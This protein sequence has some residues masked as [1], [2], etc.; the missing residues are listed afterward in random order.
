M[1]SFYATAEVVSA[2]GWS[3]DGDGGAGGVRCCCGRE[4]RAVA[5]RS[6]WRCAARARSSC[7]LSKHLDSS[8]QEEIQ[9]RA[10]VS[11]QRFTVAA[12]QSASDS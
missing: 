2:A 8:Q 4:R 10:H 6:L 9:S 7:L 12:V 1:V 11:P 5:G 3:G